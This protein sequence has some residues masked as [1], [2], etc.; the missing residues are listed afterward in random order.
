MMKVGEIMLYTHFMYKIRKSIF[1]I[2]YIYI[3]IY[4]IYLIYLE[5]KLQQ[6]INCLN[7]KIAAYRRAIKKFRLDVAKL[8]F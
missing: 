3:Y 5:E 8:L 7:E 1:A 2:I 6:E 4:I